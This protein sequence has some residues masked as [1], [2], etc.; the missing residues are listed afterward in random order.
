I[1]PR[2]VKPVPTEIVELAG[3]FRLVVT[4]EDNG[5]VGGVG[6]T[7]AREV[8]GSGVATPARGFGTA[9]RVLSHAERGASL[10]AIGL[11]GQD[12]A[13]EVAGIVAALDTSSG[14]RIVIDGR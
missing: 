8:R 4:V 10:S 11:T 9:P 14:D 2:W 13:R 12:L 3:A 7:I 5:R 1:D 6:S